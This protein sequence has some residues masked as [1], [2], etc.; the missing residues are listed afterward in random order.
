MMA[1]LARLTGQQVIAALKYEAAPGDCGKGEVGECGS[2]GDGGWI[3]EN[4]RG[5]LSEAEGSPPK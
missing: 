2:V 4:G 3:I 1:K 5:V